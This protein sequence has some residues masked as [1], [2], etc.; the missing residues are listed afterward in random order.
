MKAD[1]TRR[2]FLLSA[3]SAAAAA[4]G[5]GVL[6]P[7]T[8]PRNP[9][10][11]RVKAE[12]RPYNGAPTL[13]INGQA[14][15]AFSYL[16]YA[17][18]KH[19]FEDFT[20]AGVDL[21]TFAANADSIEQWGLKETWPEPDRFDYTGE[22]AM[23]EMILSTNPDA[24]IFPRIHAVGPKWW[25]RTHPDE[26]VRYTDENGQR[27]LPTWG[28][29][30]FLLPSWASEASLAMMEEA[31]GRYVE[32]VRSSWYANRVIGYHVC[33]WL[34]GEWMTVL[35]D[36]SRP[37]T[38]RFRAFLKRKYGNVDAL[39]SAWG[40]PD[41]TFDT[42]EVPR[43]EEHRPPIS[44]SFYDIPADQPIVDYFEHYEQVVVN[45]ILRLAAAA[46]EASAH[47]SLVGVFFGYFLQHGGWTPFHGHTGV[48]KVIRSPLV[49][50][51]SAPSGYHRRELRNGASHFM[52][53]AETVKLHGK[54]WWD[55]N[56]YRTYLS[57]PWGTMKAEN[58]AG[59]S[60]EE[61][62]TLYDAQLHWRQWGGTENVDDSIEQQQRQVAHCISRAAGMW[63]FDMGGGWFDQPRF[64]QAIARMVSVAQR[65]VAFDRTDISD[66]AVVVDAQSMRHT[67]TQANIGRLLF[68]EQAPLLMRTG[69]PV[70]FYLLEDIDKALNH[71]LWIFLNC[72]AISAA[73]RA[74]IDR[75]VKRSRNVVVWV[76]APGL[77]RMG[78]FDR[79]S[80]RGL[81]GIKLAVHERESP[82]AVGVT[83]VGHP[84]TRGLFETVY[85]ATASYGGH[86]R[87]E[88]WVGRQPQQDEER[89]WQAHYARSLCAPTVY[90]DDENALVLG[91]LTGLPHAGLAVRQLKRWTS[92]YSSAGPLPPVLLRNLA[93][94]AGVHLYLDTDDVVYA[95]RSFLG[96]T[97]NAG[98]QRTI[99]L[100]RACDVVEIFSDKVI[101]R[102]VSAFTTELA[103]ASTYLYYLGNADKWLI[104]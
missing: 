91:Y 74:A 2:H 94:F 45:A 83:E 100:P 16:S 13:F 36:S 43:E 38:K 32:H 62:R 70:S 54:M 19:Y 81:T 59:M 97:T 90:A 73:A 20:Q 99:R 98:G 61:R 60:D 66:I 29:Q 37:M 26:L 65:S 44:H 1:V 92:V 63:W 24:Y 10:K 89:G 49:D 77:R 67:P 15:A 28:E 75:K 9:S 79:E 41:V 6:L 48:H 85:G 21:F 12:I 96:V 11:R 46:K 39:R 42:V 40:Q 17:P 104:A 35:I 56:D 5:C 76:Y 33:S 101:A 30:E 18:Q 55:E 3:S 25:V 7:R 53:L 93:R 84:I 8:T 103:P 34:V 87:H 4:A 69:A 95:N 58:L 102:N 51:F 57:A 86:V 72:F 27:R 31:T 23:F 71:R 52:G 82:L 22:D 47:E 64:M 14:H 80:A 68:I 78:T 50:F 88:I